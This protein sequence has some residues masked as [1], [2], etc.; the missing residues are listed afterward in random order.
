MRVEQLRA[1]AESGTRLNFRL[2]KFHV[3]D[4]CQVAIEVL[5]VN[6]DCA[7]RINVRRLIEKGLALAND[8]SSDTRV[9]SRASNSNI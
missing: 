7:R 6:R 2:L 1:R 5:A 8:T 4:P 9:Q 3:E